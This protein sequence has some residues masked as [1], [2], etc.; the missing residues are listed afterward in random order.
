M[1]IAGLTANFTKVT[2]LQAEHYK[3]SNSNGTAENG[4]KLCAL[5]LTIERS[6]ILYPVKFLSLDL[7]GKD[8]GI[9]T[10]H[11]Y[12]FFAVRSTMAG[13]LASLI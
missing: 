6:T 7:N 13:C 11:L 4:V 9:D 8:K 12:N 10:I 2:L 3:V 1:L 5:N